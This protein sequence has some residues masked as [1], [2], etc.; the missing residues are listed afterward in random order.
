MMHGS[1]SQRCES[2]RRNAVTRFCC[3]GCCCC[4]W[5]CCGRS[6]QSRDRNSN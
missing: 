6:R 5:R 4:C 2:A 1:V 3:C